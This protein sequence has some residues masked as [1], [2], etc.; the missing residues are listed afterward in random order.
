VPALNQL[1]NGQAGR[2]DF[3]LSGVALTG[4]AAALAS[5]SAADI[6]GALVNV[7]FFAFD[8]NWQIGTPVLWPWQGEAD[9]LTIERQ[10]DAK[11]A[12][13]TMKFSVG[14]ALTGRRRPFV[15]YFTDSD[16]RQRSADDAFF[17]EIRGYSGQSTKIWPV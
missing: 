11:T 5:T 8:A 14:T 12:T 3:Q 7:G 16:Q 4:E 6:R 2:V 13:R 1:I 10:G 15:N 17:S 9:S